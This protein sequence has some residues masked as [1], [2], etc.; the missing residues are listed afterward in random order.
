MRRIVLVVSNPADEHTSRVVEEIQGLGG[1]PVLFFPEELGHRILFSAQ[2]SYPSPTFSHELIINERVIDLQDIYSIWYRRPRLQLPHEGM[3]GEGLEFARDEWRAALEGAYALLAHKFWVSHPDRLRDA[4][5][6]PHQLYLASS[7]GLQTPRTLITNAPDAVRRFYADCDG[8][9]IV[10]AT[11]NGWVYSENGEDVYYVLTNRITTDELQADH[12]IQVA[13]L[14]L[15]EEIPKAYE[16]RANIVGN[17]ALAVRIDSQKSAE[18]ELDW[19]RYDLSNTPYSEYRLPPEIEHRCL[20]LTRCLGLEF[21]AIDLIRTPDGRYVFLE[22]NGNGQF[23]WAE[24]HS[25]V[26]V[27]AALA[28]LL[29]GKSRPLN[30]V[31]QP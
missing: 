2:H 8:R 27:S 16:V 12:E 25:G 18:S 6:K 24:D 26:G 13:P 14:T 9:V 20:E 1:E 21:G 17:R 3:T 23:L 22:I 28:N 29:V 15:Q 4:A 11:G 30:P 31:N 5:R 19:R 10:K 7:L